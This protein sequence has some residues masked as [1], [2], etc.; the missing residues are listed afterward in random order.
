MAALASST[1]TT[2]KLAGT[3]GYT[4]WMAS[5][6]GMFAW[7]VAGWAAI[8]L[9]G[10]ALRV[11]KRRR[12]PSRRGR[13][14][15]RRLP[16][17]ARGIALLAAAALLA[18]AA[19]GSA[20]YDQPDEHDF[21]FGTLARLNAGLAAVPRGHAVYLAARLDGILTPLRP[22]ITFALRRRGV[23]ALG[24]GAYLR[25]GLW[26][27]R[28]AHPYDYVLWLYDHGRNPL[29]GARVI[30]VA[31]V[32]VNGRP[33]TVKLLMAPARRRTVVRARGAR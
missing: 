9:A 21:E 1:P 15:S 17:A 12:G 29:P 4:L 18:I 11:V 3:L 30:A 20:A 5:M 7:L 22:E 32:R 16:A 25:L 10:E 8:V 6:I 19:A 28:Y 33:H 26:Y 2:P 23:Q 14:R 27:E 31:H 13:P 24:V